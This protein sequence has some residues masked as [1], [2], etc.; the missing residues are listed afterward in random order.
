M[1]QQ[2]QLFWNRNRQLYPPVCAEV[3]SPCNFHQSGNLSAEFG[4]ELLNP[5]TGYKQQTGPP[6]K[7]LQRMDT[8]QI[9]RQQIGPPANGEK[10][11][12]T[13]RRR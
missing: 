3:L 11:P 6:Q 4:P 2:T 7:K 8:Q 12:T 1:Q 5:R 10:Y 9:G 13:N